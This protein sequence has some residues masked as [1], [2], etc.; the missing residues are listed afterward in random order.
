MAPA[1][2]EEPEEEEEEEEP[3]LAGEPEEEVKEPEAAVCDAGIVDWPVVEGLM[4][5]APPVA[6]DSAPPV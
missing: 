5:L 1:C 4:V 3:V 2:D 6:V